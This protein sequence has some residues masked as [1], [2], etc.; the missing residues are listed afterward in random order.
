[1]D[2]RIHILEANPPL[3]RFAAILRK[4]CEHSLQRIKLLLKFKDVDIVLADDPRKVV[5]PLVIGGWTQNSHL[6]FVWLNSSHR[7]FANRIRT[8]I[9]RTLAHELH[10]VAR[11]QLTGK[12]GRNLFEA[13]VTEGLADHFVLQVF[14]GKPEPWDIVLSHGAL[15]RFIIRARREFANRSY[16][17]RAWFYGSQGRRIPKWTGYSLG[18][19]VVARY[20]EQHPRE[21]PA[22]L[23]GASAN[24][25][26]SAVK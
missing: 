21:T 14:D 3:R 26:F 24:K 18:F 23:V 2:P 20:L 17:H 11:W 16:D 22:R 7:Y 9:G 6:V 13:L 8:E 10:H 25:F 12:Y 5:K 1:M 15:K 4:E 19:Y